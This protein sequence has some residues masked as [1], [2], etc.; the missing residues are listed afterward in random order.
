MLST[1]DKPTNINKIP[2]SFEVTL[3]IIRP[4]YID[5][6]TETLALLSK[7]ESLQ[8]I[9][10]RYVQFTEDDVEF[11]YQQYAETEYFDDLKKEMI[12]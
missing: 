4:S 3:G 10:N 12:S 2:D 1:L 5:H 11:L 6:E 8:V 9:T 7:C